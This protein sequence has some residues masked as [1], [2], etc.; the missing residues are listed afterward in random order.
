[1]ELKPAVAVVFHH[2]GRSEEHT[3]ELQSQSNIVC[4]L[5]LEK[6]QNTKTRGTRPR[7]ARAV[8]PRRS[9]R[10]CAPAG[11]RCPPPGRTLPASCARRT[12]NTPSSTLRNRLR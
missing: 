2:I 10:P 6:K 9:R 5:L 7:A 3:S 11:G 8:E 1:M 4:R 12:P